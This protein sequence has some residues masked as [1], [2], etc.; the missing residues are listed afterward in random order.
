MNNKEIEIMQFP[1]GLHIYHYNRKGQRVGVFAATEAQSLKGYY[2][3]G[4][5]LCNVNIGDVFDKNLAK[6]IAYDR[7]IA[8]SGAALPISMLDSYFQFNKIAAKYFKDKKFI[9]NV[10]IN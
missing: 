10:F 1:K 6:K 5:S 3:I 4:W 9:G 2:S 7:A 8:L